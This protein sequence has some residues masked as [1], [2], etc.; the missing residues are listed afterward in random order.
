M[1]IVTLLVLL[2]ISIPAFSQPGVKASPKKT[3]VGEVKEAG[4]FVADLYYTITGKD[5]TY[6]ITYK[7]QKNTSTTDIQSL[8]FSGKGKAADKLYNLLSS[9]FGDPEK[10]EDGYKLNIKLGME[11]ITLSLA[12]I[13]D[14]KSVMIKTNNGHFFLT[15]VQVNNLF[16]P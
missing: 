15:E 1:R 12:R 10:Q 14:T 5:T 3:K 9:F 6:V 2:I 16:Y 8:S 4:A 13:M 7:N 11:D